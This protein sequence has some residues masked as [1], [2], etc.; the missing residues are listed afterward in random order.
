MAFAA[1]N[2]SGPTASSPITVIEEAFAT[3]PALKKRVYD[4]IGAYIASG[5]SSNRMVTT[6]VAHT[7]TPSIR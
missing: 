6:L 1:I 7:D 2:S 3:E 5:A 4:A